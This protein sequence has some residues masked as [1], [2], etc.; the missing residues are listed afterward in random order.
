MQSWYAYDQNGVT[1]LFE[2]LQKVGLF[3]LLKF[4]RFKKVFT[5]LMS[6]EMKLMEKIHFGTDC[7]G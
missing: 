4:P 5:N 7:N 1:M 6:L 2:A 3:N